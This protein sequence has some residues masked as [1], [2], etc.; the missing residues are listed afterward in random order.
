MKTWGG[1]GISDWGY[2]DQHGG[3]DYGTVGCFGDTRAGLDGLL[4][5]VSLLVEICDRIANYGGYPAAVKLTY[6][7]LSQKK[8]KIV[9]C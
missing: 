1:G 8:K 3:R 2:G 5:L 9:P 4:D 6:I 7:W